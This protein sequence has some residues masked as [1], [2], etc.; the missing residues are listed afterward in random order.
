VIPSYRLLDA[1]QLVGTRVRQ[2][3]LQAAALLRGEQRTPVQKLLHSIRTKDLTLRR[4]WHVQ[5]TCCHRLLAG[6]DAK[7]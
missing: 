1:L 3:V 7:L 5:S 4:A 2:K 6:Q